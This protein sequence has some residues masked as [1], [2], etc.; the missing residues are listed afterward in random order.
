M[1]PERWGE[2]ALMRCY[3]TQLSNCKVWDNTLL[4]WLNGSG[5]PPCDGAKILA[6]ALDGFKTHGAQL[7]S[8]PAAS[9]R[10]CS[11]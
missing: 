11:T 9:S 5:A 8:C 4:C 7:A 10:A 3:Q 6:A 1:Q 2:Q